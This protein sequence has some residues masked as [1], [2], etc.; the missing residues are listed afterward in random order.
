VTKYGIDGQWICCHPGMYTFGQVHGSTWKVQKDAIFP[1][2]FCWSPSTGCYKNPSSDQPTSGVITQPRGEG[3]SAPPHLKGV[4]KVLA[5]L[6]EDIQGV[7]EVLSHHKVY[8]LLS[9]VKTSGTPCISRKVRIFGTL[10]IKASLVGTFP[11]SSFCSPG[12][13]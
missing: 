10:C 1:L 2:S 3:L 5:H 12:T 9:R 4:P 7:P 6:T 13:F 11:L 8:G